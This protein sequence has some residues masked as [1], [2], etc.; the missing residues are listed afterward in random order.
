MEA[1]SK[2]GPYEVISPA[3]S[4]GMGEVYR[5]RD[6]RLGREVAIKV[7]PRDRLGDEDRRLR[8]VQEA[9]AASALNHPNIVTIHEIESLDGMDFIVMEYV[10]GRSLEEIIPRQG[11]RLAEI[12]RL[13]IPIVDALATAHARGIVHRDIKPQNVMVTE[14]GV[15]KVLD[16]GLAKLV[17]PSGEKPTSETATDVGVRGVQSRAGTVAG[18]L[19]YMSPE[20]AAAMPVDSRSD[21]FSFGAVLYEMATGQ[22]AFGGRSSAEVL[23]ALMKEQPKAPS[24]VVPGLPRE[25]DRVIQRCLQKD[26]GRRFQHTLDVKLEL[27]QI[28]EESDTSRVPTRPVQRKGLRWLGLGLGLVLVI[29]AATVWW[30]RSR[31]PLDPPRL[32]PVTSM[33]GDEDNASLSP[34]GEQ[35]VFFWDGEKH[36]NNDIYLKMIGSPDMRRLTTAPASETGPTWSP[37]GK[38]IAYK[39]WEAD[40]VPRIRLI[41]PVTG[42]DRKLSDFPLGS[43]IS[44]SPDSRWLAVT[45]AR[46][47][48]TTESPDPDPAP[49]YY[50][51]V[52]G[53]PPRAVRIP[54][55]SEH[56]SNPSFSP[57][58][59]LLA[60]YAPAPA[61]AYISVVDLGPDYM[62][63][64]PPR[65]VTRRPVW[66]MDRPEWTR[67]GKSLLYADWG[68]NRLWRVPITGDRAPQPVDIAGFGAARPAMALKRDRLV[69]AKSNG[70]QSIYRFE[71]GR[72]VEPVIRSSFADNDPQLSPDGRRVAFC[73][74]RSGT[75]EVWIAEADGSNPT[76]LTRGQGQW[77]GS[78]RWSPDGRRI[79]FDA[80]NEDGRFDIWIIDADGGSPRRLTHGPRSENVPIWSRDGRFIYFSAQAEGSPP[81]GGEGFDVWR[82]PVE[83]G[84]E[85]RITHGG[86]ARAQESIDGT[87]LFFKKRILGPYPLMGRPVGG[88]PEREIA[89]RVF[90]FAVVP[91]G[92]Y[93]LESSGGGPVIFQRDPAT[94][95]GRLVGKPENGTPVGLSASADGK[96]FLYT[97]SVGEGSDVM[98]IDNF[99]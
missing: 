14:A 83:G 87:T 16:F 42:S 30:L 58:G 21:V 97:R 79:A 38:L 98:M 24:D 81:P 7:L 39:R 73:S 70:T 59:R 60:Y 91:A 10:R 66:A 8:F 78:P 92:L 15:V 13:A 57:D 12:L 9:R 55:E 88:G 96:T 29:G 48:R 89:K 3:G 94:G 84:A 4:G 86:G 6:L 35:V 27:E 26:P 61:A 1:G 95:R 28:K 44:W 18:T 2:L 54:Q 41:S 93:T 25:L 46:N 22:R 80:Q 19:G 20:Q 76:Q 33:S 45:R 72:P 85:E 75:N 52:D 63:T 31:V 36:D 65:R 37:D 5:A 64:G 47:A 32:E 23:A 51:P 53:G 99:R 17:R 56:V 62:P 34:D 49:F 68:I 67:D 69:F 40:G 82:I 77:Q 71:P 11:M 74:V 50:L 43:H 90:A